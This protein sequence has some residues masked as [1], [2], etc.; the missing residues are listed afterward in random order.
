MFLIFRRIETEPVVLVFVE[1]ALFHLAQSFFVQLQL[2]LVRVLKIAPVDR[3]P[4]GS[5]V[6]V[7]RYVACLEVDGRR[8]SF[9]FRKIVLGVLAGRRFIFENVRIAESQRAARLVADAGTISWRHLA[10]V[11]VEVGT[12][13]RA[14]VHA[15]D[16]A[17]DEVTTDVKVGAE[18]RLRHVRNE[19]VVIVRR[20]GRPVPVHVAGPV[21]VNVVGA[22]VPVSVVRVEALTCGISVLQDFNFV[23]FIN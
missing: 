21:L 2:A 13:H 18:L 12:G 17:E 14:S 11:V 19:R 5:R 3:R 10:V 1:I 23:N 22:Q 6:Q 7:E 20:H 8:G 15:I 9:D 16:V 4:H